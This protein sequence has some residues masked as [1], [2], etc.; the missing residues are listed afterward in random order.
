MTT[1]TVQALDLGIVVPLA[2]FTAVLAWR[3]RP[4]GY[5]LCSVVVVKSFAMA[6]AIC[7]M[8]LSAWAVEGAVELPPLIIFAAAAV[9]SAWLGARMYANIGMDIV[10]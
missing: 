6:A 2:L 7:A 3:R 8:L 4:S 1:M 5:L 10:E 9:A